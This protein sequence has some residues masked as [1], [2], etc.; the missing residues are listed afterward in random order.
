MSKTWN[1]N[2]NTEDYS[3]KTKNI[4]S[5]YIRGRNEITLIETKEISTNSKSDTN[6]YSINKPKRVIIKARIYND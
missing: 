4:E 6:N 2:N 5:D 1:N 3:T